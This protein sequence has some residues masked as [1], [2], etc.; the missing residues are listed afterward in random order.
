M[1]AHTAS[2]WPVKKLDWI[3]ISMKGQLTQ[4]ASVGCSRCGVCQWRGRVQFCRPGN[5]GHGNTTE[6]N[7]TA[8]A[9]VW[10]T[11]RATASANKCC[12]TP[13]PCHRR[14]T[15]PGARHV[16]SACRS[17]VRVTSPSA[18]RRRSSPSCAYGTGSSPHTTGGT[19]GTSS[20]P[21][22]RGKT[23]SKATR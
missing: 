17:T 9:R 19:P 10:T 23:A 8:V 7:K 1:Y 20:T 22:S 6:R 21:S 18:G 11:M 12:T 13:W 14:G 4:C 15:R 5:R 16:R 2:T 3:G